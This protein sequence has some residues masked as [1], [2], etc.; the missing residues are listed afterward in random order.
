MSKKNDKAN[1]KSENPKGNSGN[2]NGGTETSFKNTPQ[3]KDDAISNVSFGSL[4]YGSLVFSLDI[5]ANDLGGKGKSLWSVDD[6]VNDS[7]AMDG[8]VAGDLLEQDFVGSGESSGTGAQLS[9][10]SD[11][12]I[13]YDASGI[14]TDIVTLAAGEVLT[15]NFIYAIRLGNGTLS[16]AGAAFSVT[17]VNDAPTLAA[18]VLSTDEDNGSSALDL[19]A[20]GDDVDSDDDGDSLIYNIVSPASS[21]QA[22]ITGLNFFYDPQGQFEYLPVGG[23]AFIDVGIQATDSHGATA[24][25]IVTVTITGVNDAPTL[26]DSSVGATEDGAQV[27]VDLT[28]LGDDIDSDDDGSSLNYTLLNAAAGGSAVIN[29]K[30]LEFDPGSDFQSLAQGE[31]TSFDLNVEAEDSHLATATNTIN[32]TVTGVNDAPTLADDSLAASED[33]A[34]VSVDLTALG[35]DI[36][37]DDDGSTLNYSLLNAAAGGSAVITGDSLDYDPGND[38]QSL[39][40]GETTGFDLNVEASDA[41]GATASNKI[42]VTITGVNDAPTLADGSIDAAEDGAQVSI[43]LSALGD[44]IDSDDDGSSL[45]YSLLNAAPGG[46]ASIDGTALD[47]DPGSDF[48][49]LALG[50]TQNFDLNVQASDTHGATASNTVAVTV[51]GANDAPTLGGGNLSATE[52]GAQVSIDLSALGADIDS[53]DDGPSLSYSL[54]NSAPAGS[55]SIDGTA[56]DFDTGSGFQ[57]LAAGETTSFDLQIQAA[58]THAATATNAIT[59]TVTGVNDDPTIDGGDTSGDVTLVPGQ[60]PFTVEQWTGYA[61]SFDRASLVAEAASRAADYSTTTNIIDYTDD[62]GGFAGELPGSSPWP[63]AAANGVSGTN[64]PLNNTFFARITANIL[65]TASDTYTFRTFNDD[66]VYLTVNNQQIITDPNQH[67]EQAFTGSIALDPGIYPLELYFFENGGE[68][69]LELSFSDSAGIFQHVDTSDATATGSLQFSDVD[70]SDNHTVS[71]AAAGAVL[72]SLT[73]T[74]DAD[75]T[76]SGTGGI[77]NWEFQIDNG[78]YQELGAGESTTESF[79]V[80]VDDGK[81]GTAQETVTVTI[82][83]GND[84]PTANADSAETDEDTA[85]TINVLGNDTDPDSNDTLTL[86]SAANGDNGTVGIVNNQLVYT[87]NANFNGSDSFSYT[88]EDSGGISSTAT[89]SVTVNPVADPAQLG[90]AEVDLTETDAQQTV[91]GVLSI[92][93]PDAG[94]EAF[95]PQSGSAGS[96]GSFTIDASGTWS[97]TTDG[98]LDFLAE[99][100]EVSDSFTVSS[101]DGSVTSVTVNITGTA[102]GPTAVA[103]TGS[104]S[105]S[106]PAQDT[107]NTVYWVDWTNITPTNSGVTDEVTIDGTITLP[108]RTIGVTYTG[109]IYPAQTFVSP[110]NTIQRWDSFNG[111]QWLADGDGVYTSNEVANGPGATNLDFIALALADTPRNL[112]FTEPVANLFF[113]VASMNNNGYLFDQPFTVVSSAEGPNDRGEWGHTAGITLS[114]NN[115]QHGISTAGF[116]P[117]EFHGVLAINNA[118]DSLTWVSQ[119]VEFWQGFTV[120][121][122]GV[123]TSSTVSGNVIGNDD[124]GG[125]PP[126]EV[127]DVNGSAMVGNSVTLNLA[128]GAILK[129]DRDGDYLYDDNNAFASLTAG[130]TSVD[131]VSYTIKDTNG[132]TDSATLSVTVV[133]VNDAPEVQGV[134]VSASED[135]AAVTGSFVGDDIDSDDDGNSLNYAIA[136][137]PASGSLSNNNDGSF[138]FDPGSDFQSLAQGETRTF[139]LGYTA[140]DSHGAVSNTGALD[141]IVSGVNDAP[142]IGSASFDIS[143]DATAFTGL[144]LSAIANDVDSDDNLDSLVYTVE[145]ISQPGGFFKFGDSSLQ[146]RPN[147]DFDHLAANESTQIDVQVQATDQHGATAVNTITYN[148]IGANDAPVAADDAVSTDEDVAATISIASLLSNDTDVDNGDT[149]TLQSVQDAVNGSVAVSGGDVVFTPNADFNGDASFTYTMK[150][151]AGATS[152]ATVNVTVNPV[153]DTYTPQNLVTNGSFESGTTGWTT[154]AGGVD[155]VSGWEAAD[156]STSLDM[157]AFERGGV[158]QTISTVAGTTYQGFPGDAQGPALDEVV[159]VTNEIVNGF[160]IGLGGDKVDLSGLLTSI[161]AP[162]NVIAFAQGF[163]NF[164]PSGADTLIQI[165]ADGSAGGQDYLTVMTLVGVNLTVG[166]T[167][168][169]IL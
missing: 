38:F 130:Q 41:H 164:Q 141:I 112:S 93:D 77:V 14:E 107:G 85:V 50:E 124:Q 49:S 149:K 89:V 150:D 33:G 8:Y 128:S 82:N 151:A 44:D 12:Q 48:Q 98:A 66:G 132:N 116:S 113:A 1:N 27:S 96:Y 57:S 83:G 52:D 129:V 24:D 123:A 81:G 114:E 9:L 95:N 104:V 2:T 146:F 65:I 21:G 16:W 74:V 76:G 71:V 145:N 140:T 168:N 122:Y 102:D 117:N 5:L 19:S 18:G 32:V 31:T 99:G 11:G 20:L 17:G 78:A 127:S 61:G 39:A 79:V 110:S 75:T 162:H 36:D 90:S 87:P 54:L 167:D 133:G 22:S 55:A 94:E 103:D 43:D 56:L 72:G 160:D 137:S 158:E 156:G 147:G 125:N 100:Q 45:S 136:G 161:N 40:L 60:T 152:T 51:T 118:V 134:T 4:D 169:Y 73:A 68:A 106:G 13:E 115:G 35:D 88:M 86:V 109:Q 25:N 111:S 155:V 101:I 58:D 28:A 142:T 80:T 139:N 70:L 126:V 148:V 42:A 153:T 15:D 143:E 97:Y 69:S 121:T 159:V 30:S 120:G 26:A 59:V 3:A 91:G 92:S 144:S 131:T 62:P 34:Q 37:S 67:G 157:N 47:Y 84:A 108:D 6:G 138:T 105:A 53:D 46:S 119:S 154:L 135:G 29:N 163:V 165:D 64:H 23:E 10:T 166:D 63:A 7:G